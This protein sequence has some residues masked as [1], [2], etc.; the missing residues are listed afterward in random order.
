MSTI[1]PHDAAITEPWRFDDLMRRFAQA[2]F[3]ESED[4]KLNE[5]RALYRLGL[6]QM[7]EGLASDS[8]VDFDH[9]ARH[10]EQ[11][12]LTLV[13]RHVPPPPT[14]SY[15]TEDITDKM[16]AVKAVAALSPEEVA[17]IWTRSR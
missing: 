14:T 6:L 12:F 7:A 17:E 10:V 9:G 4:P 3:S 11:A 8:Y 15:T 1:S 2:L 16:N 5:R 13:R